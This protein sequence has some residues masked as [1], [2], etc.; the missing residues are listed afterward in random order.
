MFTKLALALATTLALGSAVAVA[1]QA[2]G[3]SDLGPSRYSPA[4]TGPQ[5]P[6]PECHPSY[7]PRADG[8]CIPIAANVR[9]A[10]DGVDGPVLVSGRYRIV[11]PDVYSLDPDG[12]GIACDRDRN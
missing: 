8:T 6:R 9:C 10:R 1:Q 7:Q 4:W 11:G 2:Y 12:D 3:T 5:P